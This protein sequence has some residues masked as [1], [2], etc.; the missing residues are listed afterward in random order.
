METVIGLV[1]L[2]MVVLLTIGILFQPSKEE[3]EKIYPK[4]S[5][6]DMGIYRELDYKIFNICYTR[7]LHAKTEIGDDNSGYYVFFIGDDKHQNVKEAIKLIENLGLRKIDLGA[8][9][10]T[11]HYFMIDLKQ[12]KKLTLSIW[13]EYES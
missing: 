10:H 11:M 1:F 4:S 7:Y 2:F 5:K 13:N 12:W 8:F 3:K 6:K 9:N